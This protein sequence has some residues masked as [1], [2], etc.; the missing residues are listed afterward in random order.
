MDA[1]FYRKLEDLFARAAE[2]G[3]AERAAFLDRECAGDPAVR[4]ELESLLASLGRAKEARFLGLSAAAF[5]SGPDDEDELVGQVVGPYTV[6]ARLGGGGF[7]TVYRAARSD[8]QYRQTV[9]LKVLNAD[10]GG[11]AVLARF[12]RERQA[13]AGLEGH[14]HIVTLF[15]AGL[16]P[17][18]RPYFVMELRR[19]LAGD[20]DNIALKALQKDPARRYQSVDE[21]ARDVAAYLRSEP[22]SARG[23][24]WGYRAGKLLRKHQGKLAAAALLLLVLSGGGAAWLLQ[25]QRATDLARRQQTDREALGVVE[26]GRGLLE[27][28]WQAQDPAKLT[29][30]K[31]EGGR[32]VAVARSG[33]ASAAVQQQAEAF[34]AEAEER[35]KRAE[36]NQALRAALL[37]V[38][39]PQETRAYQGGAGGRMTALAQ[40]SA[41]EQYAAAFRRWGL[42]VDGSPEAEVLA[43][44]RQEPGPV[45]QELIA[46][47]DGW[48][49]ERRSQKRP[50]AE[51]RRLYRLAEQLARIFHRCYGCCPCAATQL[52]VVVGVSSTPLLPREDRR[53]DT[54]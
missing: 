20:L 23:N 17:D 9:A 5:A 2:L 26:R 24:P 34:Q 1:D 35:L 28:G 22:V 7:G 32:A 30:A 18:G 48:M 12:R 54:V 29:E 6:E 11:R 49:R 40:P 19:Q 25:H 38:S 51:W 53:R 47:L 45:V 41:N 39:A 21:L 31:A 42:D 52:V 8:G 36:R 43:R 37:D 15:D 13:L 33:G 46:A 4:A 50:E 44:L 14:P 27:A 16:L 3:P 10:L